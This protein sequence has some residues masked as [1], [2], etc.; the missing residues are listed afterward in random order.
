M[1]HLDTPP[2][3]R[4]PGCGEGD[5]IDATPQRYAHLGRWECDR[6]RSFFDGGADEWAKW[7]TQ[8]E[9][10]QRRKEENDGGQ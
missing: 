5:H 2:P 10:Y 1:T 6:C 4:C 9:M 8:R 3:L 7:Q